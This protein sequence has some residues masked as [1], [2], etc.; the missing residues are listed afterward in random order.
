MAVPRPAAQ[1]YTDSGLVAD[2]ATSNGNHVQF[3]LIL[4]DAH[5]VRVL[6]SQVDLSGQGAAYKALAA[7]PARK[8][9]RG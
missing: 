1:L 2:A 8:Q 6:S 7:A 9:V 5:C 4:N 3:Q